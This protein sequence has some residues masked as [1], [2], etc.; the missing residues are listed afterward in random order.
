MERLRAKNPMGKWAA[1]E[2]RC[3]DFQ[4]RLGLTSFFKKLNKGWRKRAS[5]LAKH[6]RVEYPIRYG[7][8]P[9]A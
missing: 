4:G 2:P 1:I 3:G 6:I 7:L 8:E 5:F 9:A